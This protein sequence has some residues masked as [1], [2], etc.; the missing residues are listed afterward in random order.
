MNNHIPKEKLLNPRIA[1]EIENFKFL[2]WN[3]LH[4]EIRESNRNYL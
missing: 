1:V 4:G 2:L 3:Y